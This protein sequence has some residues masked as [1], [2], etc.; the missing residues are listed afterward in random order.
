[1]ASGESAART[2]RIPLRRRATGSSASLGV[3]RFR[4]TR[5]IRM[6]RELSCRCLGNE[7]RPMSSP[8][9]A[10][11]EALRASQNVYAPPRSFCVSRP[12]AR[13]RKH[14]RAAS[15]DLSQTAELG[16]GELPQVVR[17]S[18]HFKT[19]QVAS[20]SS[21]LYS[22]IASMNWARSS[23]SSI[24]IASMYFAIAQSPPYSSCVRSKPM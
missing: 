14:A 5:R 9:G 7:A 6:C 3:T 17:A 12:S 19:A 24:S 18:S 13:R 2:R 22:R 4:R 8:R 10:P 15:T 11:P 23:S 16:H 20:R 1:M 21:R